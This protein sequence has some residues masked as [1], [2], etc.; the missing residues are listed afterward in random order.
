MAGGA[1]GAFGGAGLCCAHGRQRLDLPPL[2]RLLEIPPA[3]EHA[4]GGNSSVRCN[5]G[6]LTPWQSQVFWDRFFAAAARIRSLNSLRC[7]ISGRPASRV[8]S[9]VQALHRAGREATGPCAYGSAGMQRPWTDF[10]LSARAYRQVS[11]GTPPPSGGVRRRGGDR[12]RR[13]DRGQWLRCRLR[14]HLPRPNV[15]AGDSST[16]ANDELR[17]DIMKPVDVSGREIVRPVTTEALPDRVGLGRGRRGL[18]RTPSARRPRQQLGDGDTS[19]SHA[20]RPHLGN[21]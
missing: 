8:R 14:G 9:F 1:R 4:V 13:D 19:G 16:R 20:S 17:L 15:V 21:G 3:K 7:G 11:L 2:P 10:P 12:S 5:T 18:P 6:E